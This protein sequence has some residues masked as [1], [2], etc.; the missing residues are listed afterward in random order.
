[1]ADKEVS[2]LTAASLPLSGAE[3]VHVVQGGNSREAPVSAL[4]PA[5]PPD[6]PNIIVNGSM[7]VS[8]ENANVAG[9]STGYYPADQFK[10]EFVAATAG[11]S[12]Q[13]VQSRSLANALDQL[14]LTVT[15]AKASLGASDYV[16]FRTNIE[17]ARPDF[18]AAG[19][20]TAAAKPFI[21]RAEVCKPAG[22][23]HFHF[24][25]SAENRHCA[26][27]YVVAPG[28]A[29]VPVVKE[30]VV[31]ADTSGTW[32]TGEGDVGIRCSDMLAVGATLTGGSA[33][34]WGAT[35]YYAASTQANILSSTSNIA[36]L[37]DVGMKLDA[38]AVG[39]YGPYKIGE[40][41]PVFNADRYWENLSGLAIFSGIAAAT[42]T[43]RFVWLPFATKKAR[44][45]TG[46]ISTSIGSFTVTPYRTG[47]YGSGNAGDTT[48]GVIISAYLADARLT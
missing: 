5:S 25:N 45:P 46:S 22:T 36:Y 9:T 27:P 35:A 31:P 48:T 37:A 29:N 43:S 24:S 6:G 10:L 41:D 7:A 4:T 16:R 21:F 38:D 30:V 11:L 20:G 26:V 42:S 3:I 32:L 15:T 39:S 47:L 2:A 14:K 8:A 19:F 44:V 34:T 12:V 13:R 28:E 23:Y 33:S 1:M 18:I 40:V 17:G